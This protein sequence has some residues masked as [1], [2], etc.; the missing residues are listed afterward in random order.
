MSQENNNIS[1]KKYKH[2]TEVERYKIE[3]YVHEGR[4]PSE[5]GKLL[6]KS[7]RTIQREIKIGTVILK[8]AL[9]RD[10]KLYQADVSQRIHE[11]KWSN[12]GPGLK[13]AD[14]F[15]FVQY[16]E[17]GIVK[18]H[19]SPDVLIGR[20]SIE[21]RIFKI[22][23]CT[24]TLY[25]YIHQDLFLNITSKD[26]PEHG[27]K[28]KREYHAIKRVSYMNKK[29]KSIEERPIEVESRKEYGHWEMDCVVGGKKKGK[30][31]LLV[32]SERKSRQERIIKMADKTMGSVVK[33]LNQEE[34]K[35]GTKNFR[36]TFKSITVDNGCEF[37]DSVG[38]EKSIRNKKEKR[39]TIYYAHPYSSWERGTNE[40]I[41]RMIRR[42][43]PKGSSIKDCSQEQI[44][45]I[46]HWLNN[47]PRRILGYK[48][49]NE[50]I[51]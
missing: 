41:N 39:T 4:K 6:G 15:E 10:K 3:A 5:I 1:I 34:R 44:N 51:A 7:T 50:M 18:K 17:E 21:N 2:L 47:Y 14:D 13:I 25:N 28:K 31:V 35:L 40:N 30:E 37:M 16:I 49:P 42:F 27:K 8:D 12:K 33:A 26:L 45:Y 32:L 38:M 46:E 43:V 11:E 29:G 36:E 23:I 19:Y 20:I 22:N 9:W 24:K 48:T